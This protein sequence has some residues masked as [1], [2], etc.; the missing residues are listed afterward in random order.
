MLQFAYVIFSFGNDSYVRTGRDQSKLLLVVNSTVG[1]LRLSRSP[2]KVDERNGTLFLEVDVRGRLCK[3]R[4]QTSYRSY[5]YQVVSTS[6]SM[7]SF[8]SSPYSLFTLKLSRF[9]TQLTKPLILR[10]SKGWT[11]YSIEQS[12]YLID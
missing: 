12:A 3:E 5:I 11:T 1:F 6:P 9:I 10:W 8:R 7:L 4:V 2:P